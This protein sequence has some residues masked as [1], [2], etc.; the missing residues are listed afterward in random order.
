MISLILIKAKARTRTKNKS[1]GFENKGKVD[2]VLAI[3]VMTALNYSN[4]M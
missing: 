3:N 1:R 4:M 2:P